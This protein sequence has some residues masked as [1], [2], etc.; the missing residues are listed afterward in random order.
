MTTR[1]ELLSVAREFIS[2]GV[3]VFI[4]PPLVPRYGAEFRYPQEWQKTEAKHELLD[5]WEPGWSI[6]AVTGYVFDVIDVDPRN[7]GKESLEALQKAGLLPNYKWVVTTPSGGL[8]LY[9]NRTGLRSLGSGKLLPGIDFKAGDF[10]GSGRGFVYL[11][12]TFRQSKANPETNKIPGYEPQG[13]IDWS[14]LG[15]PDESPEFKRFMDL[16]LER[17]GF[18]VSEAQGELS[19]GIY[20]GLPLTSEQFEYL[21]DHLSPMLHKLQHAKQGQRNDAL[22][23]VGFYVGGLI[24]GTGLD[25]RV[26]FDLVKEVAK[27]TG[28][29]EKEIDYHLTRAIT[30]GRLRP[31]ELFKDVRK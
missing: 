2:H 15:R 14:S 10:N 13:Q 26:A 18:E 24:S 31:V 23:K 20:K 17:M 4:A 1:D 6:S 27:R 30:Q 3:P 7:G 22:N 19:D 12:G 5:D 21:G 28:L 29:E 9:I 11:P 8:H 16:A 25:E